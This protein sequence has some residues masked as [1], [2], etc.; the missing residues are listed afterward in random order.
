[1]TTVQ[2]L[3]AGWKDSAETLARDIAGYMPA[4]GLVAALHCLSELGVS[5]TFSLPSVSVFLFGDMSQNGSRFLAWLNSL[6]A[7]SLQGMHIA[8]LHLSSDNSLE[9]MLTLKGATSII[10]SGD[11]T[12]AEKWVASL[13][14]P[15]NIAARE[16]GGLSGSRRV[17][18]VPSAGVSYVYRRLVGRRVLTEAKS[19][20]KVMEV[21]VE[22]G[23]EE[24]VAGSTVLLYPDNDLAA[25][26]EVIARFNFDANYQIDSLSLVHPSI[27]YRIELPC[28]VFDYFQRYVDFTSP[29]PV[30]F[31]RY[32]SA[33]IRNIEAKSDHERD[34]MS[35]SLLQLL[36]TYPNIDYFSLDSTLPQLPPLY[37]RSYTVTSTPL[38]LSDSFTLAMSITGVCSTYVSKLAGLELTPR[39]ILLK[40]AHQNESIWTQICTISNVVFITYG[41]GIVAF[42]GILEQIVTER[43]RP[44]RLFYACRQ[45]IKSTP[46]HNCDFAYQ[47]EI[48]GLVS[49]L[50]GKVKVVTV[51]RGGEEGALLA[52]VREVREELRVWMKGAALCGLGEMRELKAI[53]TEIA[54]SVSIVASQWL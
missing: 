25:V 49:T 53:L 40:L 24:A 35:A 47:D 48:R 4:H 34:I 39:P 30:Y 10:P 41:V 8:V 44:V 1:M 6:P 2:V 27:R 17:V 22:S 37:P 46:E 3:F 38:V 43:R 42:R 12:T 7:A 9:T 54:P 50:G 13:W 11:L 26:S 31:A 28:N 33:H 18:E 52:A 14:K 29:V 23:G 21:T 51:E 20:V 32:F 15:L 19:E 45:P 16:V 36:R 5:L